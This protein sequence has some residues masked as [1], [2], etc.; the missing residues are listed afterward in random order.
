[1]ESDQVLT[2]LAHAEAMAFMAQEPTVL[3]FEESQ[4]FVTQQ[5]ATAWAQI[6][7]A[8]TDHLTIPPVNDFAA[9]EYTFL[10]TGASAF[11][12][13]WSSLGLA[14]TGYADQSFYIH[15]SEGR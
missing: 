9:I 2:L 1:M 4:S 10:E 6:S 15:V 11:L 13:V 3:E 8:M 14:F 12:G 5:L 7:Q